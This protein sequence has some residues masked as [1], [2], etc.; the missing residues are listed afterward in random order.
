MVF[1]EAVFK[2]SNPALFLPLDSIVNV[3]YSILEKL[4][5]TIYQPLLQNFTKLSFKD[6]S[7]FIKLYQK[8]LK[9]TNTLLSKF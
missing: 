8:L 5:L 9:L 7:D 1:I 4:L 6:L 3:G 2:Q